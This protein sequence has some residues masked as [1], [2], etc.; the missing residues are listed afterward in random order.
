MVLHHCRLPEPFELDGT[1]VPWV[2]VHKYLGVTLDSWLSF[3]LYVT[4]LRR[5]VETCTNVL[6]ALARTASGASD[7]VLRFFYLQAVS[8]CVDYGAPCLMTVAPAALQ[9]LETAQNAAIPVILGALRWTKC[10]CL[11]TEARLSS[12]A[13][14]VTQLSVGHLATVLRRRGS[15]PTG[16]CRAGPLTGPSP[17]P[18]ENVG[19]GSSSHAQVHP[20][21]PVLPNGPR[22]APPRLHHTSPLSTSHLPPPSDRYQ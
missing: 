6:R 17:V 13:V 3:A 15:E 8:T 5:D 10:I 9:P 18:Q 16:L 2:Q 1:P 12:V 11:W 7:R 14:R 19:G 20:S 4:H 21:L 22:H